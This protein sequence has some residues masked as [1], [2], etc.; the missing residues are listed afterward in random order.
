MGLLVSVKVA[1]RLLVGGTRGAPTGGVEVSAGRNPPRV[2]QRGDIG[3]YGQ[4][5]SARNPHIEERNLGVFRN[6]TRIPVTLSSR[7][8]R[9]ALVPD[10]TPDHV[11]SMT[12][13]VVPSVIVKGVVLDYFSF[14]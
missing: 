2:E 4:P 3:W 10:D 14:R 9:R 7:A 8:P 11:S 12:S 5:S 13:V 6:A 1:V